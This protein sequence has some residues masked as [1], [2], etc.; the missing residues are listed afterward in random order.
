MRVYVEGYGCVLNTA[1][2][3]IIKNSLK[4]HGFELVNSLDEADIVIINTCVVRLETENRMIYRIN[5]LKNLGKDVVVAGCLPKALK[6]KVNG[7]FHIY[8]REAH[9]AG[10]ILRDYIE[11][12]KR[13][14][15]AEE[16]IK[17]FIKN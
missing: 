3:E 14:I 4:E 12:N 9:R 2:T 13:T 5:E 11:K 10:E 1:D 8:P 16:L 6:N 15:Y 17:H 7:F